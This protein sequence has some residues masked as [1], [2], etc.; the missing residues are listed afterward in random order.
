MLEELEIEEE[1]EAREEH[2]PEED[3][4]PTIPDEVEAAE[5]RAEDEGAYGQVEMKPIRTPI[6]PSAIEFEVHCRTHIPFRD[7][8]PICVAARGTEDPHRTRDAGYLR[9]GLPTVCL[10][11]KE[12][13]K[14][15]L[16]WIVMRD[17]RTRFT[18][19]HVVLFKGPKDKWVVERLTRDIANLGYSDIILKGDG[20]PALVK[21]MEA[22]K[23]K[24]RE[25]TL[26]ENPHQPTTHNPTGWPK[27]R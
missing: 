7:W 25:R 16:C 3:E 11:Y 13:R 9:P 22:I 21:V 6:A 27:A 8:C 24:R 15:Q 12:L 1:D 17:Q 10:D 5:Q 2:Q 26:L 18:V 4:Q 20:E 14:G 19:A 23:A